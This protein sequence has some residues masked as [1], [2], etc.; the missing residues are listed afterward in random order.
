[1]PGLSPLIRLLIRCYSEMRQGGKRANTVPI[2]RRSPDITVSFLARRHAL[3][4][5]TAL[6]EINKH[7]VLS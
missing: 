7:R 6:S 5:L 3:E 1:M 4:S 2:V